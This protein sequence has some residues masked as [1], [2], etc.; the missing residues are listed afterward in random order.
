[1]PLPKPR[2]RRGAI[3]L[4]CVAAWLVAL[5]APAPAA[6]PQRVPSGMGPHGLRAVGALDL[7]AVASRAGLRVDV[8]RVGEVYYL[9]F[10]PLFAW[11]DADGDPALL[12][13]VP[14]RFE[15]LDTRGATS[16]ERFG[17]L[18]ALR[19]ADWASVWDVVRT[20]ELLRLGGPDARFEAEV[21]TFTPLTLGHGTWVRRYNPN[22][23][24]TGRRLATRLAGRAP[25]GEVELLVDDPFDPRVLG[26]HGAIRPAGTAD[27]GWASRLAVTG[28]LVADIDAPLMN[29]LDLFDAD[30]DGRRDE[31]LLTGAADRP[32]Y[33]DG[34]VAAWAVGVALG[35][36]AADRGWS[37]FL[38]IGGLTGPLPRPCADWEGP[39][40]ERCPAVFGAVND[41]LAPQPSELETE[42]VGALGG[43]VGLERRL[44]TEGGGRLL[45]RVEGRLGERGAHFRYFDLLYP[46]QRVLFRVPDGADGATLANRTKA[47]EVLA[48]SDRLVPALAAEVHWRSAGGLEAAAGVD[49][50]FGAPQGG[51]FAHLGMP[52]GRH[53]GWSLAYHKRASAADELG[54]LG[55]GAVLLAA[56]RA[57]LLPILHLNARALVPLD[58]GAHALED[59]LFDVTLGVELAFDY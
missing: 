43:V 1:M 48:A 31:I 50:A 45:G 29:R 57:T 32:S 33:L 53:L 58:V 49:A 12:V 16:D 40:V 17:D 2:P 54:D 39:E 55:R 51:W 20:V 22:L 35:P 46:L 52:D 5:A 6:P 11:S 41:G 37:G 21:S 36:E 47:R 8:E 34:L 18:F 15:L 59:R 42:R 24:V 19:T 27:A 14:L 25:L 4:C 23:T 38:E 9:A 7:R 30:R 56:A 28:T 3:W 10:R 26:A 13:S 44:V